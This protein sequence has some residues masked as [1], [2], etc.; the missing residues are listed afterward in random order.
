MIIPF[1]FSIFVLAA[2]VIDRTADL[3]SSVFIEFDAPV[4]GAPLAS[5]KARL[6]SIGNLLTGTEP[7]WSDLQDLPRADEDEQLSFSPLPQSLADSLDDLIQ[8]GRPDR[9]ICALANEMAQVED[10]WDEFRDGLKEDRFSANVWFERDR[11]NLTLT[12]GL[13][14]RDLVS[15]WDDQ[16]DEAIESGY[17]TTP[18]GP[19]PNESDWLAPLIEYAEQTG[20]LEGL[21]LDVQPRANA[22]YAR[23]TA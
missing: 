20:A 1:N 5:Q 22:A 3:S 6:R 9:A 23:M 4:T 14:S 16:V 8:L 2:P 15:L 17:L 13:T 11:K 19:R 18:R 21:S 7:A 10:A 12:D